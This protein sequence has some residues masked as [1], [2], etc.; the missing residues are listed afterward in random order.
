MRSF[1][2]LI[3]APYSDRIEDG[4]LDEEVQEMFAEKL[5]ADSLIYQTH[6]GMINALGIGR[7]DICMACLNREYPTPQGKVLDEAAHESW[8]KTGKP[9]CTLVGGC[10][11]SEK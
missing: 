11:S 2:E 4:V 1:E 6:T 9:D 10:S 7:E 3:A 5:G 8:I